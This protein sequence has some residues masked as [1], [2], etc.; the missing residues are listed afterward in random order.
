MKSIRYGV[1]LFMFS[2]SIF[3][4]PV[5]VHS[6]LHKKEKHKFNYELSIATIFRDEGPYLKEWI[7]YHKLIGVQHFYLYNHSSNDNY[8]DVLRPYIENNQVELIDW[9][10]EPKNLG[11]WDL[12]QVAAYRDAIDRAKDTSK[13]LAIIDSDEFIVPCKNNNL[14]KLLKNAKKSG[15]G[16]VCLMWSFFGTSNVEKIPPEK[17]M[18]ETLLYH[19]GPAS[20]GKLS[21]VWSSGAYKSIVQPKYVSGIG[22]PHYCGYKKNKNHKM[23]S[24]DLIHINHYWTRDEYYLKNF[25]IPRRKYWGQGETSVRS[26]ASGMNSKKDKNPILKFIPQL[27][28][29]MGLD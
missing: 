18:I 23:L 22:S 1:L 10:T 2:V 11:E 24:Y 8:L 25:K 17:L 14:I 27:R 29:R 4:V 19:S 20:G 26:W 9:L 15:L 16:G 7:E 13:W 28:V 12:L 6:S 5:V 21:E 3:S